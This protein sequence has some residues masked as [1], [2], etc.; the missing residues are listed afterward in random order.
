[1][2]Y[3]VIATGSTGNATIIEDCILIDC[4]VPYKAIKPYADKLKVVLLTHQHGDHFNPATVKALARQRP[5][6]R[7]A[8]CGWMVD[9]LLA[10]GVNVRCID[11]MR[12][13][14]ASSYNG[15]AAVM[16]VKIPHNVPNCGWHISRNG[17]LLFYATDTGSLDG[18]EAKNYDLYMVEANHTRAELEARI[19]AKQANGEYA[20][21]YKAAEN[22]LS[23]EQAV[24]WLAANMGPTSL[25]VPMHGHKEKEGGQ[26]HG[27]ETD[28]C[29]DDH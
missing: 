4:G 1:M 8:C 25:W 3:K 23:Y 6:L 20:Y 29:E 10:A 9:H 24:D 12:P 16:P 19:A 22:H 17:E 7:W 18:V 13:G 21:E 14:Y 27:R 28:A 15:V 2:N 26:D 5:A 11:V